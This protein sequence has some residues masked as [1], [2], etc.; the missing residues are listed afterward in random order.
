MATK[1]PNIFLITVH[2]NSDMTSVGIPYIPVFPDSSSFM[3]FKELVL[4]SLTIWYRLPNVKGFPS[5][6]IE[7]FNLNV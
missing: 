3:G 5:Y 6:K 4:M 1:F 7:H 2:N